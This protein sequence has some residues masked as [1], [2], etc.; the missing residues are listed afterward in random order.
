MQGKLA[1]QRLDRK[2][3]RVHLVPEVSRQR[4]SHG[5]RDFY[6]IAHATQLD[7]ATTLPA[8]GADCGSEIVS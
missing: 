6:L 5:G 4:F 3:G 8:P 2:P 7:L 1:T